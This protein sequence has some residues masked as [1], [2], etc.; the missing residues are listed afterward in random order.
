MHEIT[1]HGF[2]HE[3]RNTL[4]Y[5]HGFEH[6]QLNRTSDIF[7]DTLTKMKSPD[8]LRASHLDRAL[9]EM[10][11]HPEWKHLSQTQRGAIVS[12]FKDHLGIQDP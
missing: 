3:I 12:T 1:S 10:Q 4:R 11:T 7:H 2:E 5:S 6:H 8:G 9:E